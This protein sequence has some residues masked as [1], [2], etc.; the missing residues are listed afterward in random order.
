MTTRSIIKNPVLVSGKHHFDHSSI[1]II[2]I[3]EYNC[4]SAVSVAIHCDIY[5]IRVNICTRNE[6][7]EEDAIGFLPIIRN[8]ILSCIKKHWP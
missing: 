2:F 7:T 4:I 1:D 8:R 3:F 5:L 6:I